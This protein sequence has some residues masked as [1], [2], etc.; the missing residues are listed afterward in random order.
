[1]SSTSQAVPPKL[2]PLLA[3]GYCE[4]KLPLFVLGS[5][6][7]ANRVPLLSE[8]AEDLIRRIERSDLEKKTKEFLL[9][10]GTLIQRESAT[11]SDA[12][13]FFSAL[14]TLGPQREPTNVWKEFCKQL[15]DEGLDLPSRHFAGIL[16]H[17]NPVIV[18]KDAQ[19]GPSPS[20]DAVAF[21]ASHAACH[22][23]N[24]NYDALLYLAM[25]K[26]RK[27]GDPSP[28]ALHLIALHS[29]PD[30][31][32]YY[33]S[34]ETEFQPSVT[35]ARGDV[36]YVRC[37]NALCP[38]C[39][40]DHALDYRYNKLEYKELLVCSACHRDTL[41]IQLSFPSYETKEQ[42]LQPVLEEL[43][44]FIS[45]RTSMIIATGVSGRWD[46]Y[47]LEV[48]FQWALSYRIPLLGVN[49]NSNG[50]SVDLFEQFRRRF[51]PS[52]TTE[53][54]PRSPCYVPCPATADDFFARFLP[55]AATTIQNPDHPLS[56]SRRSR[57]PMELTL[58]L[59]EQ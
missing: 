31:R 34:R 45:S 4:G 21:L 13:Q 46:P 5:G 51:F 32:K 9:A 37:A 1:M 35:N 2:G 10:K 27:I 33:S 49:P 50:T 29:V 59:K 40:Q 7:S 20:H 22:I 17:E 52:I 53:L 11:R 19:V 38:Q 14:Q 36:F 23:L 42:L 48:L 39:D 3:A 8:M 26:L 25:S 55:I 54:A 6:I 41:H 58:P 28:R 24:L 56:V 47:L 43:R 57:K 18:A 15:V 44:Y 16:R 12:A 30:I